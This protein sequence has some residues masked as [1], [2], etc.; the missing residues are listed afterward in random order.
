[1]V[2][3]QKYGSLELTLDNRGGSNAY[4]HTFV[5]YYHGKRIGKLHS[6]SKFENRDVEFNFEK[7]VLYSERHNWWYKLLEVVKNELGLEFNNINLLE[8]CLDSTKYFADEYGHMFANSVGNKYRHGNYFRAV[9]NVKTEML[10]NGNGFR[11][12]GR[13]NKVQLYDKRKHAE[14]F[15]QDFFDLN[16]LGGQSNTIHTPFCLALLLQKCKRPCQLNSA[17]TNRY[18]KHRKEK[19]HPVQ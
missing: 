5:V 16:G 14:D 1:V 11:I 19:T 3:H 10:D 12:N 18:C 13:H 15:I 9:R 4:H 2:K 8:I 17:C 7:R 6:A